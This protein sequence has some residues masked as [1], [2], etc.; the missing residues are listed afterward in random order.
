[1][2]NPFKVIL[3]TLD[4]LKQNLEYAP[5]EPKKRK[6]KRIPLTYEQ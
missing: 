3:E 6:T 1:M 2:N 4:K 5:T